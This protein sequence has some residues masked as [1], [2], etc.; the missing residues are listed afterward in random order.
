M[1]N[2][3][4]NFILLFIANNH[5]YKPYKCDICGKGFR[6]RED[7]QRHI[8]TH[9]EDKPYKFDICDKG[10]GQNQNLQRH[11]RIHTGDK[12][13]K[14]DICGKGFNKNSNLKGHLMLGIKNAKM[15]LIRVTIK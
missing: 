13:Y 15:A 12:P 10:F 8:R 11:I 2:E 5:V 6:Q 7:L 14:C 9:T 1:D 4:G 3:K